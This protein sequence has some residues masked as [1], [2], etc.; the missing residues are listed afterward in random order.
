M[1]AYDTSS[2]F[3][4]LA[5]NKFYAAKKGLPDALTYQQEMMWTEDK[6][7]ATKFT[8][9]EAELY[10]KRFNENIGQKHKITLNEIKVNKK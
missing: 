5:D 6:T 3:Y 7:I 4:I 9:K 1:D 8:F 2:L 10:Y